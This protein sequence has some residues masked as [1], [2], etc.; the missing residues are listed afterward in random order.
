VFRDKIHLGVAVGLGERLG[1]GN[2]NS[3][4]ARPVHLIITMI[5]W[6]RTSRLSIKNSRFVTWGSPL[7]L[8]KG[9]PGKSCFR[10]T[11]Y[12][13]CSGG[14]QIPRQHNIECVVRRRAADTATTTCCS[15]TSRATWIQ[16]SFGWLC[17]TLHGIHRMSFEHFIPLCTH[18]LH[19]VLGS[20]VCSG[21]SRP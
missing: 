12:L 21:A 6:I 13:C 10:R 2:S 15:L 18:L 14:E 20:I 19:Q 17:W 11:L 9:S 4:G 7:G 5:K 16:R 3:H 1:K 8:E